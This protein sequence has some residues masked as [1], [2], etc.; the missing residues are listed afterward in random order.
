MIEVKEIY[1]RY[2]SNRVLNG[3]SFRA[4]PG[5]ITLLVGPNGAGKTTTL[6]VLAGLARADRGEAI[7]GGVNVRT[8]RLEAQA[9]TSFLPQRPDF[10]PSLSTSRLLHFYARLRGCGQER[11]R[12][13]V[14]LTGL[15]SV[16]GHA[17]GTLSGG[18]RQRLGLALLFL[19][20]NP[21]LILDEPGLSLDPEWRD[22]LKERLIGEARRGKTVLVATHLLGEWEG[23]AH[24]CLLCRNGR[25]ERE[26]DPN[27][28]QSG[29]RE[30]NQAE[31]AGNPPET[32]ERKADWYE[33]EMSG[34]TL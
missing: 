16:L 7:V 20:D 19:P 34:E 11:I 22:Q 8:H 15:E 9:R 30:L 21:L 24:R 5:Q 32:S 23:N 14:K 26:L 10:H 6:R 18:M 13:V 12:E 27:A 4:L 1:K 28:L 17:S 2:R 33:K 3:L 29:F 31:S 25:I